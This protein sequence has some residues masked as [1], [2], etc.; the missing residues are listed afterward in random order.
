MQLNRRETVVDGRHCALVTVGGHEIAVRDDLTTALDVMSA[1]EDDSTPAERIE[2]VLSLM[3][4]DLAS[5]EYLADGDILRLVWELYGIDLAGEHTAECA[6]ARV[7]DWDEDASLVRAALLSE[8]GMTIAEASQRASYMD[9][10]ALVGLVSR[11]TP[12]GQALYYRSA[13]EPE[14]ERERR[15]FRRMRAHWALKERENADDYARMSAEADKAFSALAR[16]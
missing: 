2:R 15:E 6:G 16:S 1:L 12:L 13:P 9:V 7:F 3:L 8:Y 5:L 10:C 14:G 11:D 4:P